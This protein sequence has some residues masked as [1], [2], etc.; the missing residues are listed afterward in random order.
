[1]SRA[2]TVAVCVVGPMAWLASAPTSG[3]IG[4]AGPRVDFN[5]EIR[6]IFANHCYAC[7]GPDANKRKAGLRLDRQE[8]ALGQLDSGNVALVPRKLVESELFRRV[9]AEDG[10]ARMPPTKTGKPLTAGQVEL[11]RRWIEQGAEWKK[12]WAYI[13]PQRPPLPAVRDASWPRNGIDHFILARLEKLGLAPAPEADRAILIR[14]LSFDLTGLPP[15]PAEADAFVADLGPDAYERLVDRLLASPSFGE[16]MASWW[17]DL[18]RYADT[19]GYHIDNQRD[20]WRWREWVIN[21]LNANQPFDQFTIEQIAGDL[22]PGAT[23]AQRIASGFNRNVMVNFEGG[24]DPEEYLTKYVEDRVTTTATVWL[25]TTLACTECHDH[26]Y[27]PF[28]Q[29]EFYQLYAF[30]NNVPEKGLDGQ[31]SNPVPSLQ[32]PTPGQAARLSVVHQAQARI[33]ERLR[34][35]LARAP[36]D[37]PRGTPGEL[38]EYAWVDGELPAGA[39]AQGSEGGASWRWVERPEQ[40]S[41]SGAKASVRTAHGL[42]QHFFTG[43]RP[44]L[45]LRPGDRL[46]AYVYLDPKDPPRSVM[47]QFYNGSWEHRAYW[48][49]NHFEWG[50]DGTP[51]RMRVGSLPPTG[52]WVRLEVSLRAVGLSPGDVLSGLAFTQ[53][54]G[55]VYWD[56]AGAAT[57]YPAGEVAFENQAEWEE[58][59]RLGA[60]P[61][62]PGS[63]SDILKTPIVQRSTGQKEDLRRYF[64]QQARA[65]TRSVFAPLLSEQEKWRKEEER[66]NR[67]ISS[68]MVMEEMAKPRE[69]HVLIRGD[70]QKKGERVFADVPAVL[71]PLPRNAKRDRLALARWLV[72]PEQPLTARVTVNRLW[73]QVFGT[74]LVK[75]SEDFGSQGE[76]PS[77]PELLD[78]L[79]TEF[80]A[81]GWDVKDF[82]KLLVTSATYRQSARVTS[83]LAHADPENRLLGRGP[84]FRLPAEMIHDNALAVS[85]LLDRRL[86]GPSVR[87]YQ[88]K[89]LW[90]QVAFGESFSAQSYV[91]S[92]GRDLYR[93]GLY[94]FWKRSLPH[95]SLFAF[96]A[97]SREVCT[98]RRPRTNTPLQALVLM[99]DPIYVECSRVLGQRVLRE[100]GADTVGRLT[101]AFKL[102]TARAPRAEELTVLL[103]LYEQQLARFRDEPEAARQLLGVGETSRPREIE[104][105][106]LAAWAAVGN[107]LLNLDETITKG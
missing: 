10:A 102:C 74:G 86:G 79:A 75:T 19:N 43:G 2:V 68:T 11:I 1:M 46:F 61:K 49:E 44:G 83:E 82:L 54:D 5:R 62:L 18:A 51:T 4:I 34:Q 66:L 42:S 13:P 23:L 7:H 35:E 92:S 25:G 29:K 81:G 41:L 60:E 93:R 22:L 8:S 72:A 24:A 94:T 33:E 50:T 55:T 36:V 48:G 90:E 28:T 26:K 104:P 101:Y 52:R 70:W 12:H 106:E 47:L 64:L 56:R 6:P 97:P 96:D 45:G 59:A 100:G 98:D 14:R 95:P 17:L 78:W 20:M 63:V 65:A 57:H 58:W 89:G 105:A 71:S 85:G 31:K 53:V 76:W 3:A 87:P 88:P 107:V 73:E 27:D 103:R 21:A 77:H 40:P 67:V 39:E 69:S 15:S 16:R 84:R 91:Q 99:N 38:K 80:V 30:F 32:V 37:G 9:S